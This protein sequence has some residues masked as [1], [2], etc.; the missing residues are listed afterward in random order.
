[1]KDHPSTMTAC[2]AAPVD[3]R[4]GYGALGMRVNAG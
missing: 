2:L 3:A 1:M 4:L